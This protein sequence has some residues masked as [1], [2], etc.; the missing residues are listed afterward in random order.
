[1]QY[2][3]K[4]SPLYRTDAKSRVENA[5]ILY[6]GAKEED[7]RSKGVWGIGNTLSLQKVLQGRKDWLLR[8]LWL[9]PLNALHHLLAAEAL[10]K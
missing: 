6:R 8:E 2:T 9:A 1:M 7:Q 5:C 10:A 3:D 4:L